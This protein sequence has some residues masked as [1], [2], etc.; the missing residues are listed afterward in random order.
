MLCSVGSTARFVW[1]PAEG[2]VY[3]AKEKDRMNL[4]AAI[5]GQWVLGSAETRQ[6]MDHENYFTLVSAPL[7]G[8]SQIAEHLPFMGEKGMDCLMELKA[9]FFDRFG[10]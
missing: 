8:K 3:F 6:I 9:E 2:V 1:N 5:H 7:G 10:I 4:F